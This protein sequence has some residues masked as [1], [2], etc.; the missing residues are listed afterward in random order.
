MEVAQSYF[1]KLNE[2]AD[3]FGTPAVLER[4]EWRLHEQAG[5]LIMSAVQAGF[6]RGIPGLKELV[7]WHNSTD[8]APWRG[9]AVNL[10]ANVTG[11]YVDRRDLH[12]DGFLMG[13]GPVRGEGLLRTMNPLLF[14]RGDAVE[15][16]RFLA[17]A[18]S[19][20][21]GPVG[22]RLYA[23]IAEPPEQEIPR[24][25]WGMLNTVLDTWQGD[26][27]DAEEREKI[28]KEYNANY[29]GKP[30][31]NHLIKT[32]PELKSMTQLGEVIRNRRKLTKKNTE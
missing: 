20:E 27:D 7:D 32:Y 14:E 8:D 17:E 22:A 19:S 12:V 6:L 3:Q 29:A 9:S 2:L 10:F 25:H 28:F 4:D 31:K 11:G 13:F 24:T 30:W 18:I 1:R 16:C 5:K 23:P 15:A 21:G 26:V